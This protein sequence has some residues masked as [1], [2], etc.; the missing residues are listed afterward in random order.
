MLDSILAIFKASL[1]DPH[2]G[3]SHRRRSSVRP[4]KVKNGQRCNDCQM[5]QMENQK[6]RSKIA[7]LEVQIAEMKSKIQNGP[8]SGKCTYEIGVSNGGHNIGQNNGHGIGQRQSTMS[9]SM[10]ISS[11]SMRSKPKLSKV[12]SSPLPETRARIISEKDSP[13]QHQ[14]VILNRKNTVGS[15]PEPLRQSL[16]TSKNAFSRDPNPNGILEF[17]YDAP[18]DGDR[19]RVAPR[20]IIP[21]KRISN[22]TASSS[23]QNKL[24][25]QSSESP[26][27]TEAIRSSHFTR[28]R[29]SSVDD[30]PIMT[31][32]TPFSRGIFEKY[33]EATSMLVTEV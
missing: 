10:R 24:H 23:G 18:R 22:T 16:R 5:I 12:E 30:I 6:L 29:S 19:I 25:D 26:S 9:S 7:Q 33:F 28:R 14:D 8:Y 32:K 20:V 15:R 2:V 21:D 1:K 13:P 11:T 27:P 4:M 3:P 31:K 17:N